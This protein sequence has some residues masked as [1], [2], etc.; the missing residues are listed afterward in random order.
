M[1][2]FF[3]NKKALGVVLMVLVI[4]LLLAY[5]SFGP[6]ATSELKEMPI[7]FLNSDEGMAGENLG[8][9]FEK[10][11]TGADS[12]MIKW[13]NYD[14]L[15][16]MHEAFESKKLYGGLILPPN[17]TESI[18]SMQGEAPQQAMVKVILNEGMNVTGA[19][20]VQTI[21]AG[22]L[23]E[24]NQEI[25]NDM[26][27]NMQNMG[28]LL[29]PEQVS[30]LAEPLVQ[31]VEKVNPVGG[32]ARGQLPLIF[33]VLLWLGS[34][35][36]SLLIWL[37]LHSKDQLA[38]R[39]VGTQLLSGVFLAVIQAFSTM[40]VVGW[41]MGMELVNYGYLIMFLMIT[42]FVFF[43]IQSSVLNWLGFKGWPLLILIWLFGL[44]VVSL[45]PEF[46]S[47]F[48]K[49]AIYSWIPFRFSV[50]GLSSILF[51]DAG[52]NLSSMLAVLAVIGA[53]FLLL[54]L[55]SYYRLKNQDLSVNPMARRFEVKEEDTQSFQEGKPGHLTHDSAGTA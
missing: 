37:M 27:G 41:L 45:P 16:A 26:L 10:A 49:S 5:A 35:I 39:F 54:I 23:N 52:G 18:F 42:A 29:Q 25:R 21:I 20:T 24:M 46:L 43:L 22:T 13:I 33:T 15:S 14:S 30:V 34:L 44:P 12:E 36:G 19:N 48:Y 32:Q 11:V 2:N 40:A 1:K 9:V 3:F 17:L 55:A 50:E 31:Q 53:V 28:L 51:F 6:T 8:L 38:A 47:N 7:G 4:H